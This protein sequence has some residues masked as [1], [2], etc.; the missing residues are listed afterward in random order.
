MK[1]LRWNMI[2]VGRAIFWLWLLSFAYIHF[3]NAQALAWFV[4]GYFP[5]P[6]FWVYFVWACLGLAWISFI[7]NKATIIS[8]IGIAVMLLIFIIILHIPSL[9][10]NPGALTNLLKDLIIAGWALMIAWMD[11]WDATEMKAKKR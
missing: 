2:M 1:T 4:P 8:W 5:N 9:A 3:T 6:V 10:Q 11:A 7:I